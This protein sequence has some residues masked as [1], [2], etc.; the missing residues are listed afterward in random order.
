M[1]DLRDGSQVTN[2]DRPEKPKSDGGA[3]AKS[4]PAAQTPENPFDYKPKTPDVSPW[5][6]MW[7]L[8]KFVVPKR[9]AIVSGIVLMFG[10]AAVELLKPWPLKIVL[11]DVIGQP[12]EGDALALLIAAAAALVAIAFLEGLIG[13]LLVLF[14]NR[15]G[16]S[17]V[18]EL[19]AALFDKL[20]RL[21][22]QFH[23]QRSTGDVMT[24]VTSDAKA[25]R[26]VLTN[27]LAELVVS[28]IL[29]VGMAA[30]LLWLD[31]QL[32][33]VA[34]VVA[35]L[36][37]FL[38]IRFNRRIREYSRVER[39]R[40]G[41]LASVAHETLGAIGLARVFNLEASTKK[42]FEQE[43]AASLESGFQAALVEQRFTW[44][45]DV[46]A[47]LVSAA[48]LAFG[49]YRVSVG[50]ITV[51]TLVVF[52]A[53][54]HNFYKPLRKGS[55]HLNKISRAASRLEHVVELLEMPEGVTDL[56]GATKAPRFTGRIELEGVGFEYEP[57]QAALESVSVTMPERQMTAI[58]GPTGAGKT[59]L[60]SLVP[61]L[62]DPT[63][64]EVRID[65][66]GI[67]AYT[68][69]S[70]RDQVS[71]VPQES[72]LFSASIAENISYGNRSASFDEIVE[73]AEAANALEFIREL[74]DGFE[75]VVGERGGTL[76]GGQRQRI[77]IA[78]AILR[79]STIVILDEPLAGLDAAAAAA[80]MEALERQIGQ[81]TLIIITHD[82]TLA[83]RAD[84]LIFIAEGRV[85]EHGSPDELLA[86]DGEFRRLYD[87]QR[88][89]GNGS[90]PENGKPRRT[91][92]LT[93]RRV[94]GS[95][96][97]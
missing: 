62:Y 77:A 2:P 45:L 73:A 26:D 75:T 17:I 6:T 29:I 93:L 87:H 12:L 33:L 69:E 88:G 43:S 5:K 39:R 40:E 53:Y 28:V 47:A 3:A 50:A 25:L 4:S 10:L 30:I 23:S 68:L 72:V 55:K 11:D 97:R 59:T 54:V 70:L 94:L 36:F 46:L 95:R 18:F 80:V 60:V 81:R 32:A 76:S 51:G 49:V 63:E 1:K 67:Q 84:Q 41:A 8:R 65:G 13:Y 9:V 89:A 22:L 79:D 96:E 44:V 71:F 61:R 90:K 20:H 66:T 56:P 19:R 16:R 14:L 92:A 57:G 42:R 24:R 7:R 86:R 35:P 64:G 83:C 82:L 31:W 21:S 91:R 15:A 78:R 48:A 38:L 27:S 52:V 74:P 34:I 58:V 85:A 37:Y